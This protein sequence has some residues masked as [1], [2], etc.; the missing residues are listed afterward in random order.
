MRVVLQFLF[1][2]VKGQFPVTPTFFIG[3]VIG[4]SKPQ[5]K[6]K[7]AKERAS[8]TFVNTD[9]T[10]SIGI[11]VHLEV[12]VCAYQHH[13]GQEIATEIHEFGTSASQL[14][15]F[16]Q[17]C[18]DRNP[19]VIMMKSTG[20]L[21][22]S[23]YEALEAQGFTNQQLALVNARDVKVAMCQKTDRE[24]AQRLTT[25]ARLRNLRH[26]SG[27]PKIF[28]EMRLINDSSTGA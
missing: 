16:D 25:F 15:A 26:S 14:Q 18:R 19:E 27:P 23:P 1:T 8:Q 11:N 9:Y 20:V 12:L 22:L 28:H 4:H 13:V 3:G 24:D 10:S 2:G 5:L 21:W 7:I 6:S 17:W